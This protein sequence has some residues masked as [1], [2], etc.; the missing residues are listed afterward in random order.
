[1]TRVAINGQMLCLSDRHSYIFTIEPDIRLT[2]AGYKV[3]VKFACEQREHV[4]LFEYFSGTKDD[5]HQIL[6]TITDKLYTS[7]SNNCI[8]TVEG[9]GDNLDIIIE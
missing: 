2:T 3:G 6:N 7:S 4:F 8:L 9:T 5:C 1:M